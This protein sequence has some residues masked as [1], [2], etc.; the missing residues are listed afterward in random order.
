[1]GKDGWKEE[2][3]GDGEECWR[4]GSRVLGERKDSSKRSVR[5]A[6]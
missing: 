6:C 5:C 3:G 4:V 2:H 1:M